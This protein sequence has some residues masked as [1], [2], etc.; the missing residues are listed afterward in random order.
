M[1]WRENQFFS[2]FSEARYGRISVEIYYVIV[3]SAYNH[4][5]NASRIQD[6]RVK[7]QTLSPVWR[8]FFSLSYTFSIFLASCFWLGEW[9]YW[10]TR[11]FGECFKKTNS[12]P[13]H[14]AHCLQSSRRPDGA[15]YLWENIMSTRQS[16]GVRFKVRV[17]GTPV[18]GTRL[19]RLL[20]VLGIGPKHNQANH[21]VKDVN[22]LLN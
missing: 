4:S 14:C 15:G 19:C 21:N 18:L 17:R 3:R 2:F 5:P 9:K 13:C 6:W 22:R 7:M 1:I 20:G 10:T 8:G 16:C 11:Q 12:H